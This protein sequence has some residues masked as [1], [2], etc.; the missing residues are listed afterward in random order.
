MMAGSPSSTMAKNFTRH[1]IRLLHPILPIFT[2]PS[3][4]PISPMTLLNKSLDL[5]QAQTSLLQ[6]TFSYVLTHPPRRG[7]F[8]RM[9]SD[10]VKGAPVKKEFPPSGITSFVSPP[11]FTPTTTSTTSN[12]SNTSTRAPFTTSTTS[13]TYAAPSTTSATS[14]LSPLPPLPPLPLPLPCPLPLLAGLSHAPSHLPRSTSPALLLLLYFLL[15]LYLFLILLYF[16]LVRLLPLPL[17]QSQSTLH[18]L[19]N[20]SHLLLP[21]PLLMKLPLSSCV[22]SPPPSPLMM[23]LSLSFF[24]HPYRGII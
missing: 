1:T 17:V 16:Y 2:T 20:L 22:L 23:A 7:G 11:S 6:A 14:P 19:G 5:L 21:P 8:R 15:L 24:L 3:P 13:T 4:P 18:L 10:V 12:T 9:W